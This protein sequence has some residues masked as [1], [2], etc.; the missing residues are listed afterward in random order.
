MKKINF[1]LLVLFVQFS[2]ICFSQI[3]S[4]F[5][6]GF[7]EGY[8]ETLRDAKIIGSYLEYADSRLC[9][10]KNLYVNDSK[11]NEKLYA[12]GYRCGVAQGSKAIV[13]INNSL[14][15]NVK[16]YDNSSVKGIQNNIDDLKRKISNGLPPQQENAINSQIQALEQ[17]KSNL[18]LSSK[19]IN[20]AKNRQQEEYSNSQQ[21]NLDENKRIQTNNYNQEVLNQLK[22]NQIQSQN[23]YNQEISNTLNS[24][25]RSMQAMAYQNI[26]MELDRRSNV[27]NN[28]V[29]YHSDKIT[30]LTNLYNQVPKT[31]FSKNLNGIYAAHLFNNRKYSFVNN[32]ELVTETGCLVKVENNVVKNIY[33]YGKEKFE[34]SYPKENPEN[35]LISNGIVKY[36][37][38]ETLETVTLLILEPYMS[39]TPK[40][41]SLINNGVGYLTIWTDN[42]KEEGKILYI[43]ELDDKGNIVREISTPLVYAKSEE[44]IDKNKAVKIPMNSG[45]NLLFFGEVTQTPYGRFPLYP[46]MS[47]KDMK[48]LEDGEER[49]VEIKKYRE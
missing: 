37:N 41:Y 9:E 21:R 10:S 25:S 16:Q 2:Q 30:K 26:K 18:I 20:D 17:E 38:Y 42:K 6:K 14:N 13:K 46:K 23:N 7:N 33:L 47:K 31:N 1:Y 43:Q 24:L 5:E 34:L 28:F 32:Q 4:P 36:S 49:I 27:A 15:N 8:V 3:G 11:A 19:N 45:N 29:S 39:K 44:L 12:D 22:Q 48:A 40:E 35:S